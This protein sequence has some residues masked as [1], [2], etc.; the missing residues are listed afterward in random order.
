MTQR[1][2]CATGG[3]PESCKSSHSLHVVIIQGKKTLVNVLRPPD[4]LLLTVLKCVQ[5]RV[6]QVRARDGGRQEAP[7]GPEA[8]CRSRRSQLPTSAGR[9]HPFSRV[10]MDTAPLSSGKNVSH[11]TLLTPLLSFFQGY[12]GSLIKLTSKQVCGG[13][14]RRFTRTSS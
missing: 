13:T 2:H 7:L 14:R 4:C 5:Q 6:S 8:R 9:Q 11:L 12:E 10:F 1:K 3:L